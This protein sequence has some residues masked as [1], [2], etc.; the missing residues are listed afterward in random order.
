MTLASPPKKPLLIHVSANNMTI[1]D[2]PQLGHEAHSHTKKDA[3]CKTVIVEERIDEGHDRVYWTGQVEFPESCERSTLEAEWIEKRE[4][5]NKKD[6][7]DVEQRLDEEGEGGE[8]C[9]GC[10]SLADTQKQSK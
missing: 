3:A 7:D 10:E 4:K 5:E 9:E 1:D 6:D 2:Y 8:G